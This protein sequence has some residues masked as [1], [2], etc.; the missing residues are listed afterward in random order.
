[1]SP[2]MFVGGRQAAVGSAFARTPTLPGRRFPK[3]RLVWRL[4]PI[5]LKSLVG[6]SARGKGGRI[7]LV[8]ADLNV[9]IDLYPT[10]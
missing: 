1:M 10:G 5:I 7:E 8:A 3:P 9:R 6:R 2:E 4:I